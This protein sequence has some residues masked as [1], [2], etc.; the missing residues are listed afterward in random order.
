MQKEYVSECPVCKNKT[1]LVKCFGAVVC[2]ACIVFFQRSVK[3]AEP[4]T[5]KENPIN[6][7][8]YAVKNLT[9]FTAC[10]LC[11]L[12]RCYKE[13]MQITRITHRGI[14][15]P[16]RAEHQVL[17]P[18]KERK[19]SLCLTPKSIFAATEQDLPIL[20]AMTI[21]VKSGHDYL[22]TQYGPNETYGTSM[23]GDKQLTFSKSVQLYRRHKQALYKLLIHKCPVLC[24]KPDIVKEN[25]LSS[26]TF[27]YNNICSTYCNMTVNSDHKRIYRAPNFYFDLDFNSMINFVL[28][29]VDQQVTPAQAYTICDLARN[30]L[31]YYHYILNTVQV[32]AKEV[33]KSDEDLAALLVIAIVHSCKNDP[34]AQDVI[35][36]LMN[37]WKELDVFY[38]RSHRD[39]ALVGNLFM[40]F[41]SIVTASNQHAQFVLQ[42]MSFLESSARN[43]VI[44]GFRPF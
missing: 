29:A 11:R 34:M 38:R 28:S 20:S 10:K 43:P 21:A 36:T 41:S 19:K 33:L 30:Q 17:G 42:L 3:K 44:R 6:C 22:I 5:C 1:K 12:N 27:L 7:G 39:P 18:K 14:N 4:Y 31:D 26:V 37:V 25:V 16:Q 9:A 2:F 8:E 40:L 15:Q 13:G 24:Q 32:F 35:P 23:H